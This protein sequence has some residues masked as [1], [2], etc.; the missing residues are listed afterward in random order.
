[1]FL[2]SDRD[3]AAQLNGHGKRPLD[4]RGEDE[5]ENGGEDE[6]ET[7]SEGSDECAEGARKKA[8]VEAAW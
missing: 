5:E 4:C 2:P 7:G 1:M 6:E 8:A 3:H